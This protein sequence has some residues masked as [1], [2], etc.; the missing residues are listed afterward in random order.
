M[1]VYNALASV[2]V[3]DLKSALQWY[4]RLLGKPADSRPMDKVAEEA[5]WRYQPGGGAWG[6]AGVHWGG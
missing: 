5:R 3:R 2:A 6:A 4:E 1:N